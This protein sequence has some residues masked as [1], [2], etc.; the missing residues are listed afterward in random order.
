[1][2]IKKLKESNDIKAKR[3]VNLE[4]QVQEAKNTITLHQ[5]KISTEESTDKNQPGCAGGNDV[6]QQVKIANL[7]NKTNAME[8]SITLLT[9]KLET[10]QFNYLAANKGSDKSENDNN[11]NPDAN[12]QIM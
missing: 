1:M 2:E 6:F 9:S 11:R 7:E 4:S 3:I 5:G 12:R 8:H 10:L